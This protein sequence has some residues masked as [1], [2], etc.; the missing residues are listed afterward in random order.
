MNILLSK[1][2]MN[3]IWSEMNFRLKVIQVAIFPIIVEVTNDPCWNFH[4]FLHLNWC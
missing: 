1:F 3:I 4:N 2:T